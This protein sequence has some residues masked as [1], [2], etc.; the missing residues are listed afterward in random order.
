MAAMAPRFI[1]ALL[2]ACANGCPNP[3]ADLA[4]QVNGSL[5]CNVSAYDYGW[6]NRI[7]F[8]IMPACVLRPRDANDVAAAVR[9]AMVSGV[10]LSYRSGGH[11]YTCN[12]I[13]E[14]SI[15]LDMR[16]LDHVSYA[17]GLLTT[18]SGAIMRH[19]A[20]S[21]AIGRHQAASGAIRHNRTHATPTW[22]ESDGQWQ[23]V[24]ISGDQ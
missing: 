2:I 23:S 22:I 10:A 15:H 6:G 14:D 19:K 4:Q 16:S 24:A 5:T 3:C 12:G 8:G 21:C 7:C 11:S 17:D 18:G 9:Q 1:L 20:P 13:K